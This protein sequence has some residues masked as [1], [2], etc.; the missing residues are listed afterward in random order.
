MRGTNKN[1]I[2]DTSA[3]YESAVVPSYGAKIS[4]ER[5]VARAFYMN[6]SGCNVIPKELWFALHG[7]SAQEALVQRLKVSRK[8]IQLRSF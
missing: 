7:S 3:L 2:L 4:K 8:I 5:K 6:E 1:L